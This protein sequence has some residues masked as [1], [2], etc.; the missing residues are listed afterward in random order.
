MG[1]GTALKLFDCRLAGFEDYFTKP[2]ER[3]TLFQMAE[4]DFQKLGGW[5]RCIAI[6][7]RVQEV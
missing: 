6:N 5:R 4:H 1:C 7:R 3:N 2:A